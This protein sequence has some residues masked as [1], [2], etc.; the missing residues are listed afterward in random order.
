MSHRKNSADMRTSVYSLRYVI[1]SA[2][3]GLWR[4]RS[5]SVGAIITTTIM[6][7]TLA[8]FLAINDTLNQ[9]VSALGRKSN[10]IAYVRD[11]ARPSDVIQI[12]GDLQGRSG[13]AEVVFVTKEDALRIF[14][15]KFAD[16]IDIIDILQ[17]NPLPASVELRMENPTILPSLA[18]E[19]RGLTDTFETVVVPLD[20]IERLIVVTNVSRVAGTI[21]V[22]ALTGVTLFVIV[23]TIRVAVYARRQEIEIMKLVGATDWFV[24]GPFVIEGAVIGMFGATVAAI[25]LL[26][27]YA[28]VGPSITQITSFLP[29]ATNVEYVRNLAWFTVLVGLVVGSIGSYFSV[30]RYLAV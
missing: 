22:I 17:A 4:N 6:L 1:G 2:V 3:N 28:Q 18:D 13:V 5:M 15:E 23:N 20:V 19:L 25:A 9:M 30:R 10:L 24:R 16:Q 8:A 21:M 27:L 7:I 14:Q 26:V 12:M 29:I 11:D